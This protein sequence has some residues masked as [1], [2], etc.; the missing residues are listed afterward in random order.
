MRLLQPFPPRAYLEGYYGR[1]GPEHDAL[2]SS[3]THFAREL[4][5]LFDRVVEVGCGP[6]VLPVLALAAA[7]GRG[8]QDLV[9][10]DISSESL[11]EVELWLADDPA[12]FRYSAALD[13]L[14]DELGV[15]PAQLLRWVRASRHEVRVTDMRLPLATELVGAFD[16][17]SSHFFAEAAAVDEDE[18]VD[19]LAA[20]G[21]LG[22]PGASIFLSFTCRHGAHELDGRRF[23]SLTIDPET[24]PGYL[25]R[26]QLH[27]DHFRLHAVPSEGPPVQ[28]GYD[29]LMFVAGLLERS[30]APPPRSANVVDIPRADLGRLAPVELSARSA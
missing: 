6:V 1:M 21:S 25:A 15:E 24:L 11:S 26:A 18:L 4:D 8:P 23:P 14:R 13:W 19:L 28:T 22:A 9:F 10:A 27:L 3:L 20:V 5:P 17:V 29:G 16:T 12:Q 2:L 7:L 30:P